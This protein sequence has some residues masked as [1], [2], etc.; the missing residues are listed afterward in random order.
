MLTVSGVKILHYMHG[1]SVPVWT[2]LSPNIN[3]AKC[4]GQ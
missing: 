4:R 3:K 1:M 2:S